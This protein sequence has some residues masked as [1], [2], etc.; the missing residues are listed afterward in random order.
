MVIFGFGL[1]ERDDRMVFFRPMSADDV[2][3][4]KKIKINRIINNL[5]IGH[6]VQ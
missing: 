2:E 3:D 6:H 4:G 5:V 1:D